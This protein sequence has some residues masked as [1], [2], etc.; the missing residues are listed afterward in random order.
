MALK[1][2]ELDLQRFCSGDEPAILV[3]LIALEPCVRDEQSV[4]AGHLEIFGDTEN[5]NPEET[6]SNEGL[7]DLLDRID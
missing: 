3:Q 4:G 2:S 7:P 1:H 6:F 5:D